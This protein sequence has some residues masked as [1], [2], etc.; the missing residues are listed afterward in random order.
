MTHKLCQ[1]FKNKLL[2]N[3]GAL[4][5]TQGIGGAECQHGIVYHKCAN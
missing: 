4:M 5:K 3:S 2:T 1:G